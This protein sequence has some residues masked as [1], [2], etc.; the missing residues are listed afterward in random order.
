VEWD[1]ALHAGEWY[2]TP[3]RIPTAEEV[4]TILHPWRSDDARKMA[5]G[6]WGN[7]NDNPIL[8][9]THYDPQDDEKVAGLLGSDEFDEDEAWWALLN[10][11]ELFSFGD[12]W[13]L[14]FDILPELAGPSQDYSRLP[15]PEMVA[16]ERRYLKEALPRLK[17]SDEWRADGARDACIELE[18]AHFRRRLSELYLT[19]ADREGFRTDTV[20]LIYLD[21][22]RNIVQ[23]TRMDF[24]EQTF[25]DVSVEW[26]QL[27]LP[28][29]LWE[30]GTVGEKYRANGELGR[31]F[32]QLDETDLES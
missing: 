19:I 30:E 10:D 2:K 16:R 3:S 4:D 23:E 28:L 9:R 24:D 17:Q 12:Q 32:Y 6:I 1:P 20:R 7:V 13:W 26:D 21:A 29:Q 5:W 31:E 25:A 11:P 27:A 8:L 22:K 15:R 14:V 18:A